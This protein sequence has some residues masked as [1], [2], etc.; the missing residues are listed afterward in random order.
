MAAMPDDT[1]TPPCDPRLREECIREQERARIA[2]DLHDDLGAHL[3]GI[4]MALGQLRESL[5]AHEGVRHAEYAQALLEQAHEGLHAIIDELRPPIVEFGLLDTLQW[6]ARDFTRHSGLPCRVDAPTRLD[7]IDEFAVLVV[8]RIVREAL[9]NIARHA[10]ARQ[11][12]LVVRRDGRGIRLQ[13]ADDGCGFDGAAPPR[14]G[15]GLGNM[16]HRA[17]AVGGTLLTLSTPGQ[18]TVIVLT[19]PV[20]G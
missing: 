9:S 18:G 15:H 16:R 12:S 14:L 2:R 11:V 19:L 13:V 20:A 4:G 5:G 3:T 6:V 17:Q 10:R 8:L 7:G 1:P